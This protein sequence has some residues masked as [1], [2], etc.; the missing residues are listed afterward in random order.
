MSLKP[1][2]KQ[3]NPIMEK[4]CPAYYKQT[5]P[6]ETIQ[7]LDRLTVV[8]PKRGKK[9]S[10]QVMQNG[11]A[12]KNKVTTVLFFAG[13]MPRVSM[14]FLTSDGEVEARMVNLFRSTMEV[15]I[16]ERARKVI[17]TPEDRRHKMVF[18]E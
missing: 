2:W 12:G 14:V 7:V 8:N 6:A 5:A 13:D 16:E 3:K 11:K 9:L 1:P 15:H 17:L 10:P 18:R 4:A